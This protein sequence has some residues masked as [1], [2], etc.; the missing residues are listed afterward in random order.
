MHFQTWRELRLRR[1]SSQL[2]IEDSIAETLIS[3][4]D[5]H[6]QWSEFQQWLP[7]FRCK[8]P[9]TAQ[10]SNALVE[11]EWEVEYQ[12]KA[13]ELAEKTRQLE[14]EARRRLE[15]SP[16]GDFLR[17]TRA[18]S[19][20]DMDAAAYFSERILRNEPLEQ[21]RERQVLYEEEKGRQEELKR[22]EEERRKKI[23]ERVHWIQIYQPYEGH[24]GMPYVEQV[25]GKLPSYLIWGFTEC[26]CSRCEMNRTIY[27][28]NPAHPK[29]ANA[30]FIDNW[31]NRSR[32]GGG[33]QLENLAA[34]YIASG[35]QIYDR[36]DEQ[37]RYM[38]LERYRRTVSDEETLSESEFDLL[39]YK[40][41]IAIYGV[42]W[43]VFGGGWLSTVLAG[44]LT[45]KMVE[46]KFR[47][48]KQA[49]A[50][51]REKHKE[52]RDFP[53]HVSRFPCP[54]SACVEEDVEGQIRENRSRR[55]VL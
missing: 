7:A 35:I 21:T 47:C 1:L 52:D 46:K 30:K 2:D 37:G 55:R 40:E 45:R 49:V 14:E 23:C 8:F 50:F 43:E 28:R 54:C 48:K 9:L 13:S 41:P 18:M 12:R 11:A 17:M 20:G 25:Y 22:L 24:Q 36:L 29:E 32:E 10:P 26:D 34:E 3:E 39:R 31:Q 51:F 38:Y 6:R 5:F 27:Y 15:S 16:H 4:D 19:E 42:T 33:S 53:S 44:F